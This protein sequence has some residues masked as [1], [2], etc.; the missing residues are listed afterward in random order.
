MNDGGSD[1]N[2]VQISHWKYQ[3]N[4]V[5]LFEQDSE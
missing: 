3:N 5:K 1:D 4:L 2:G